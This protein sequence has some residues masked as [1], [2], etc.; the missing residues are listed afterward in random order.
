[1]LEAG[2]EFDLVLSDIQMPGGYDGI[3]L[4]EWIKS[5][6]PTQPVTLMTG[7]ADQLDEA[8]RTGFPILAK[9]FNIDEL[10]R[11]LNGLSMRATR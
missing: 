2:N 5:T 9:P 4:A 11:L 7:Y 1:M 6:R 3:K 8:H 10:Q